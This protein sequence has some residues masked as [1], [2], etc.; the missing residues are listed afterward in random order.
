[1]PLPA[2]NVSVE[3]K[4]GEVFVKSSWRPT[5]H[6]TLDGG[7]RYETSTISSDGDVVLETGKKE[8][9]EALTAKRKERGVAS[10]PGFG[11]AE[12]GGPAPRCT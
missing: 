10:A 11:C 9:E 7:F 5:A 12:L 3:E 1:M 2:A 8:F 4:R 6:W